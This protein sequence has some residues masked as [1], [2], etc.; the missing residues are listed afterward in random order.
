MKNYILLFDMDG[1]LLTP[2][3]YHQSLMESVN[4]I[5][6]SLGAPQTELREDQ[7]ARFEALTV[8]NEWDSLAICIALTLIHIWR[9]DDS[10]RF[11]G[12]SNQP[13]KITDQSPDFNAFLADF[14]DVGDLP[15]HAA[16]AM[17]IK[18]H[19]NLSQTQREHLSEILLN[20]RD[21]Y[22]SPIL[23]IHQEIVLGS[24]EFERNYQLKPQL[25]ID[26]YLLHYD[27]PV[28]TQHQV[29]VLQDWLAKPTHHAGILTNRPSRTPSDYLS[30]PE[31][32]LGASLVGWDSM[33]LL[34]S[35]ML[36]WFAVTKHK[37]PDFVYFKPSPVHTLGLLQMIAG[38]PLEKALNTATALANNHGNKDEWL[39]L[40][41]SK[42]FIFED[43]AKGLKSGLSA[44]ERLND[45]GVHPDFHFVGVTD[46]P[47]K[48]QALQGLAHTII[49][50]INEFN[51]HELEI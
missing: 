46:N 5:G 44:L 6:S 20:C 43:S 30:S 26:S 18:K 47:I 7:I 32:E 3:G 22:K 15:G 24:L 51:W 10:I 45:I 12:I 14:T 40:H 21:I 42:I 41:G 23:P 34:G 38:N 25:N 4:R 13:R 35:G 1:V 11:R 48:Y 29:S 31:A 19:V 50:N 16:L 36:A 17:L 39:W 49:R 9:F 33:P 2:G 28:M 8:T 27:K 37:L